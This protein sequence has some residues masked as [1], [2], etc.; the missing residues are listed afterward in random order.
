[1]S[2]AAV[3]SSNLLAEALNENLFNRQVTFYRAWWD[4]TSLTVVN[5][6]EMSFRG[7]INEVNL[8]RGDSEMGDFLELTIA[9]RLRRESAV[10]Y[11]SK[12]DL[13][14]TYSGDTFF[15]HTTKIPGFKSKWGDQPIYFSAGGGTHPRGPGRRGPGRPGRGG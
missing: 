5:T 4:T 14:L 7:R 11:Y 3:T 10:S 12:E 1:V 2:L 6:A 8:N 9:T 13:S 15:D